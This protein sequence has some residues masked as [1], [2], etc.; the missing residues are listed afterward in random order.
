M[1]D[2]IIYGLIARR[3]GDAADR[4]DA[5]SMLLASQEA[6]T[7]A[8]P[9][10]EQIRDEIMTLFMAGHET[11]AN[12]LTWGLY[13]LAQHPE[14][15]ERMGAAARSGDETYVARV[16][17]E[18]L[19]LYPPAWIIGRE[20]VRD[21]T[22]V[23]GSFIPQGLTIFASPLLLHRRPEYF[24]NPER[25]DPDRW[26]GPDP[27]PFSYVPFGGGARRCIGE[28][29]ALRETAIVLSTLLAR[30]RF[31][32]QAGARVEIAPLVTLRPAGPVMMRGFERA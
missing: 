6:E 27:P 8:R 10:D 20:T 3:R 1:L 5:L 11:T 29:F 28:E 30:H 24:S 22:L 14:I 7:D 16:V 18:V 26:L 19:R 13:L 21:V 31:E 2:A 32:L 12:A 25:F 9:D 15:D 23:D 4:G 17:K